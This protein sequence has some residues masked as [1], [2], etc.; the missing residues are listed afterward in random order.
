VEADD[1]REEVGEQ[2]GGLAQEGAFGLHPPQL[3][4]KMARAR[5]SESESRLR[6][7]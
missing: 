6:E 7:A 5:T 3:C 2:A 4:W 1:P